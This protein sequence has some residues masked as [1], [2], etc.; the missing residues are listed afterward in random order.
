[1]KCR[2][3]GHDVEYDSTRIDRCTGCEG[4]A[5]GRRLPTPF[6]D[7]IIGRSDLPGE[8]GTNDLPDVDRLGDV[9]PL[10]DSTSGEIDLHWPD[11]RRRN[12]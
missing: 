2:Y 5:A 1:M 7:D 9:T 4:Q 6:A 10:P 8:P 11:L 12:Q 3:C